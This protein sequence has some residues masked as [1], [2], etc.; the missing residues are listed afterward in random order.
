[1][2]IEILLSWKKKRTPELPAAQYLPVFI[3]PADAFSEIQADL[4]GIHYLTAVYVVKRH[5]QEKSITYLSLNPNC[6][7]PI[8][9]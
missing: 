2:L 8:F 9:S 4:L 1:M 7:T 6:P 3:H 5:K